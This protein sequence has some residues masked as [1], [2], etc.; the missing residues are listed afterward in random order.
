MRKCLLIAI[1][2]SVCLASAGCGKSEEGRDS[3]RETVENN[4]GGESQG[5][6]STGQGNADGSAGKDGKADGGGAAGGK[7]DTEGS[8]K[9]E[10]NTEAGRI[11]LLGNRSMSFI[12][13]MGYYYITDEPQEL[14][15][16]LW[17][18]HIMYMDFATRKEVYLCNEPGCKHR[19]ENCTSVLT[20]D[21]SSYFLIFVAG[22]K[23]YLVNR[24]N[25]N[26]EG[27][28]SSEIQWDGKNATVPEKMPTVLYSMGLDGT[29]RK[30]EYTFEQ[31]VTVDDAVL[32]DGE[33]LYFAAKKISTTTKKGNSYTTASERKLV[34]YHTGDGTLE[35]VCSLGKD[36]SVRWQIAGCSDGKVI[37]TGR[38]YNKKLSVEEEMAL[39]DKEYW[40]Y[41]SNSK[42]VYAWL[43]LADG[44]LKEIYSIKNDSDSLNSTALLGNYLYV[45]RE[46]EKR[47]DKVDVRTGKAQKLATTKN[48]F[49]AGTLSDK[50]CC[51]DWNQAGDQ[52]LYFVDV[53]SG[54]IDH[55]TLVNRRNGWEIE[56]VGEW[57]KQ[58][59]AI[60][61]YDADD[62]G[63]GVWE[64]H[65]KQFGLIDKKD[66]Y[67]SKDSFQKIAMK[68]KGE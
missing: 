50:L 23:L 63:N 24:D 34:K 8:A 15:K 35:K 37:L 41:A 58:V 60:Y 32:W 20:D 3:S 66:L 67:R 45:S 47:I 28:M 31:D 55:C 2:M 36:D 26:E 29:N 25:D 21:F 9:K 13:D 6:T 54:K 51:Q 48:S 5:D 14:K 46:K 59:L 42:E 57:K 27:T 64:I 56:I 40:E 33:A 44:S 10:G 22:D 18:R 17:G 61:D 62:E 12:S 39:G 38:K 30:K 52:T 11:R 43:N 53:N 16:D 19:D 7:A 68:E 49:I 4:K 1:I 65:R